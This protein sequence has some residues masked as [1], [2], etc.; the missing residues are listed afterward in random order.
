MASTFF[1]F[2]QEAK[3]VEEVMHLRLS[4]LALL[5][6]KINCGGG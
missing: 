1:S 3:Y 4:D 6:I 2:S 5:I